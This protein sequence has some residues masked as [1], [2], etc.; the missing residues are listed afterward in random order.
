MK[1]PFSLLLL[2]SIYVAIFNSTKLL[3]DTNMRKCTLLPIT[4]SVGGA[5]SYKVY[6]E[7]EAYLK[8][9]R[10]CLYKTN[11]EILSILSNYKSNL[12]NYLENPEVLK[13]ISEK[14]KVG[15]LIKVK[16]IGNK[17]GTE[18]SLDVLG[19][20][21][22]DLYFKEKKEMDTEDLPGMGNQIKDW[23]EL[24]A[25]T[26]PYDGKIVGVLGDQITLDIGKKFALKE[27][28]PFIVKRPGNK[29]K[30]PLLQEIVEYETTPL[31]QGKIISASESQALG[32]M[33]QYE[34]E[35]KVNPGD[36]VKMTKDKIPEG[37]HEAE[38]PKPDL[39]KLGTAS[40]LF[41]LGKG[42]ASNT[43]STGSRQI[44]GYLVGYNLRS[45]IWVTRNYFAG[46][47]FGQRISDYKRKS[48]NL[49]QDSYNTNLGIMKIV[50]GYK[51]LPV[52]FF[53]GPQVDVY[54]GYARNSYSLDTVVVDGFGEAKMHGILIGVGANM[55][56]MSNVRAFGRVELVPFPAYKE[57][58][59][60]LGKSSAEKV[61]LMELGGRYYLNPAVSLDSSIQFNSS[62]AKFK[63]SA[64]EITYQDTTIHAGA[65]F[66][67]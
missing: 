51:F 65:T 37:R 15:S 62:K 56:I 45:E 42:N 27:N 2:L 1:K 12:A 52:G 30:H 47:E 26:I 5:I 67:F 22:I 46:L 36:W 60:I 66:S 16:L 53:Y 39:G 55:P 44:G 17:D 49:T 23:L 50:G 10:W 4:D 19:S 20:D 43:T 57:D 3:A 14:L 7:L 34:S 11:S 59:T 61:Y 58:T 9:S 25:D 40:F 32:Y 28:Q 64:S 8:D 33:N 21:G 63:S 41:A 24:Y 38:M 13:V 18:V 54:G 35:R 48:G 6:E 31:G 29:R